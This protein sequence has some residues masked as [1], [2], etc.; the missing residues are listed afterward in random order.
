MRGL[1]DDIP[2]NG[3]VHQEAVSKEALIAEFEA[4]RLGFHALLNSLTDED[5][6]RPSSNPA[7][8]NQ[9]ILFHIAVGFFLL[10]SLIRLVLF[11]GRLPSFVSQGFAAILNAAVG[12]FN[13][14]NALGPKAGGNAFSRTSLLQTFDQVHGLSTKIVRALPEEALALGMYYPERW[15]SLFR[16]YMTV[17]DIVRFPV[18]HL[19][20]HV[21]HVTRS[22][23]S[24]EVAY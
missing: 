14:V 22:G 16:S 15:D 8:T 7:W 23:S 11:F 13:A 2:R 20:L 1:G 21:G 18:H 6:H 24:G 12:P 19:Y 5:L 3:A 4:A 9:Q 17:V 10:P